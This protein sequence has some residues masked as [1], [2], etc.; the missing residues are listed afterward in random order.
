MPDVDRAEAPDAPS[1]RSTSR[2]SVVLQL[3]AR[4]GQALFGFVRGLGLTDSEADDAVQEVF[5]RLW[6]ELTGGTVVTD[7]RRWVYR[8][9]YRLAMDEHRLRRRLA[10]LRELLAS[11][12]RQPDTRD[13]ADRIA[14]WTEVD[15]LPPRQ[16]QVLHLRYRADLPFEDIAAVLGI[17]P[18]AARSHAA[19]ALA[20]LREQ[21]APT[22]RTE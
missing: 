7:P 6:T 9:I 22:G 12:T 13:L 20:T 16:R 10:R 11:P 1:E 14:V 19:H 18:G 3:E 17:T 4:H 15:R 8:A 21:L 2:Q 5:L